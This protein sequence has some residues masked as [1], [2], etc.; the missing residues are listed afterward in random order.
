MATV[1][2][3]FQK[4][5]AYKYIRESDKLPLVAPSAWPRG[6]DM[7]DVVCRVKLFDPTGSGSWWLA[8]YD[9]F[10]KTAFGL[11]GRRGFPDED[12]E[13]AIIDIDA[14]NS[15]TTLCR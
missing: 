2:S 15:N 11:E 10:T 8:S 3:S 1:T 9:P 4:R 13:L 12:A 14:P 6:A 5:P 7:A